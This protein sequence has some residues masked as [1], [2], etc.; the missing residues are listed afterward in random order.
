MGAI[1]FERDDEFRIDLVEG[2]AKGTAVAWRL[3]LKRAT[4]WRCASSAIAGN[5][6]SSTTKMPAGMPSESTTALRL[7]NRA[8]RSAA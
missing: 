7:G 4:P 3:L 6:P 5:R 8:A 1:T 2:R